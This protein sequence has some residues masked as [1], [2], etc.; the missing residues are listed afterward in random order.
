M[1]PLRVLHTI[2][3]LRVDGVVKV[4]LRNLAHFDP[5]AFTHTVC[6]LVPE[7][8]L[9][10]EYRAQGIEPVFL[11]HRG[12]R[13]IPATVRALVRLIRQREIDVVHA[14]RTLDL[15]LAGAAARRCGV[16]VIS[17]LHWL[18][19][20][21]EHPQD[22]H[23]PWIRRWGEQ[24]LTVLLNR[25]IPARIVAVSE[26]VRQS[27][28]SLPGF[29]AGRMRVVYPGLDMLAAT[30]PDEAERTALARALGI[31][32]AWPVLL[33]VGRLQA[34]KGQRHLVPAM[35]RIRE[36]LPRAVLLVAGEGEL[37]PELERARAAA[38]LDDAIRL[39]GVRS[40]VDAL[41]ALADALLLT[42]ESEAAPLPLF[43]AMRAG[44][45]VVATDVGGVREIVREGR[46]GLLVPRGDPAALADA[47]VRLVT[48]P[49]L[50]ERMG[51]AARCAG[52]ERFDIRVS[53]RALEE[54]YREVARPVARPVPR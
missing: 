33:N 22:H 16:P 21:D 24:Q 15:A 42:S 23:M 32:G 1:R 12:P 9:A 48:T 54:L 25:T 37:R 20:L 46:D 3:S 41:L 7:D 50:A 51:A 19:R 34:V 29:P 49:G 47:V 27:Y 44:R 36:R 35:A 53:V 40:D 11:A 13:S 17:S 6:G 26:A 28:A 45:P 43:E 10:P 31:E 8:A 30:A 18:G 5:D 2:R 38:G 4:V 14:N 39:L 52:R